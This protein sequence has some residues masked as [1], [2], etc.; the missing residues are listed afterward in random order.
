VDLQKVYRE[1]IRS[2]EL[3]NEAGPNGWRALM[4]SN[5]KRHSVR[6]AQRSIEFKPASE[7]ARPDLDHQL[8]VD[9][10]LNDPVPYELREGFTAYAL[11]LGV[12]AEEILNQAADARNAAT[13]LQTRAC[14]CEMFKTGAFWDGAMTVAP[15]PYRTNTFST[16]HTHY[17]ASNA[18]G[19]PTLAHFSALK[20]TIL[21]HGYG[22][23]G[24]LVGFMNSTQAELIENQAE[25]KTTNNYVSTPFIDQLQSKGLWPSGVALPTMRASGIPVCIDDWVPAGYIGVFDLAVENK[26]GRWR[27]P[28][29]VADGLIMDTNS[30]SERYK[31]VVTMYR[32][33]VSATVV[34]RGAGAIM[35]LGGSSWS[36]PSIT[37]GG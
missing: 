22:E 12:E 15:P 16:S 8:Y 4:F 18:S 26:L 30:N 24:T 33:Y 29:G 35:Y 36:D 9:F 27:L 19:S 20:Q 10:N 25:W 1:V 23:N 2:G 5:T 34:H 28:D 31:F 32:Y 7:Y 14:V 11:D 17:E 3:Y 6:V 37:V 21:E 13:R